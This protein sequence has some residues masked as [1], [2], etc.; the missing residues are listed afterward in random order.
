MPL[1]LALS[2]GKKS[3]LEPGHVAFTFEPTFEANVDSNVPCENYAAKPICCHP[4]LAQRL[5]SNVSSN[6]DPPCILFGQRLAQRLRSNVGANVAQLAH[7][8]GVFFHA[9]ICQ[10]VANV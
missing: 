7:Q 5:R 3:I 1:L 6:V 2:V 10:N 9:P 8:S 4:R